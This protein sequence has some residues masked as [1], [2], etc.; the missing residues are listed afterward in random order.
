MNKKNP[1]VAEVI[2]CKD[3]THC[4]RECEPEHSKTVH[5]CEK[6]KMPVDRY[7]F[8]GYGKSKDMDTIHN[9]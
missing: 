8:C 9:N 6:L 4:L 3:Y 2:S 5:Y 7:S 1:T